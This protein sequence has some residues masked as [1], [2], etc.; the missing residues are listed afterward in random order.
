MALAYNIKGRAGKNRQLLV[1]CKMVSRLPSSGQLSSGPSQFTSLDLTGSLCQRICWI[2]AFS[3]AG[4]D[5]FDHAVHV[6]S[7]CF[8]GGAKDE[9]KER[10]MS[11]LC[12]SAQK[13]G[14]L[15]LSKSASASLGI[16]PGD[17][18]IS[19]S[20]GRH[21]RREPILAPPRCWSPAYWRKGSSR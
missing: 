12:H 16:L 4:R 19:M 7:V 2:F 3:P 21:G 11:L 14:S 10:S 9:D 17:K 8:A 6:F 18:Q 20:G 1:A 5:S 15:V 13:D